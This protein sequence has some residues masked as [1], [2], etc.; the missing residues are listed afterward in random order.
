MKLK[1]SQTYNNL[2]RAFVAECSART[3]YEFCEYGFR[4]NGYEAI[5]TL[6]DK[7]AYQEFNHARMLYTKLQDS[8]DKQIDNIDIS[9]GLP[10]REKWD[11]LKNLQALEQDEL[12]EAEVYSTFEKVAKEEGF[13][14][15]A[16]LFGMIREVEIRHAKIFKEVYLQLK[17]KKLYK[18][19]K[20]TMWICPSCGYISYGK[21][22]WETCPLCQAKQGYCEIVLSEK[23]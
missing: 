22:A 8:E 4:Y 3:R 23:I 13:E 20:E 15:I 10:F 17:S 6:I 11:L 16:K 7:I 14:D 19:D 5:A 2:A 9:L 1:D 12:N 21:Q 18:K